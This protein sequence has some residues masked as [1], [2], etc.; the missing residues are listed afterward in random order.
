MTPGKIQCLH[1]EGKHAPAIDADVYNIFKK[2]ITQALAKKSL[3]Y[4]A[5]ND[6]V[7]N[8]FRKNNIDFD[9]SV[10]WYT[11]SVKLDMEARGL[12]ITEI[13]KGKKMHRLK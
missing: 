9:G 10:S 8:Y 12:I 5:I 2:A 4:T 13:E 3:T 6:G 7:K 1:P 11:V